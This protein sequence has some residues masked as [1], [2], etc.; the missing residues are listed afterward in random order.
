M[1]N[2]FYSFVLLL[3]IWCD[4][5]KAQNFSHPIWPERDQ[6]KTLIDSESDLKVFAGIDVNYSNI[7][8][9]AWVFT[10]AQVGVVIN[11]HFLLGLG[12]YGLISKVEMLEIQG[13][14]PSLSPKYRIYGGYGG[15]ITGVKIAPAKLI[16][17]NFPILVGAGNFE[18][19]DEDF[20]NGVGSDY[21]IERSA[22]LVVEPSAEL[23]INVTSKMRIALGTGYR[24]VRGT[25]LNYLS[26]AQLSAVRSQLSFKFGRY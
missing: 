11:K 14:N 25:N 15:L 1:K 18:I 20:F 17:F 6:P 2:T 3:L 12:G 22:C 7:I 16:H 5:C 26:D 10:G 24:L 13:N 4:N 8:D 21:T 9:A 23:E 19:S